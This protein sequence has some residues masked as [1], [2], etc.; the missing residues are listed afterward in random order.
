LIPVFN[1][2][3]DLWLPLVF[4]LLDFANAQ[5]LKK[6]VAYKNSLLE[7]EV[8]IKPTTVDAKGAKDEEIETLEIDAKTLEI[9][10]KRGNLKIFITPELMEILYLANPFTILA[11]VGQSTG[12]MTNTAVIGS[13]MFAVQ[14][15]VFVASQSSVKAESYCS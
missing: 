4:A 14:G 15:W 8:W 10:S 13:L 11:C 6:V 1:A 3:S 9:E 5:M 7:K 2:L 12:V